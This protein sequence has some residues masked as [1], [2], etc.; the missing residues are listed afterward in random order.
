MRLIPVH[1]DYKGRKLVKNWTVYMWPEDRPYRDSN[2]RSQID[3]AE[4]S[5]GLCSRTTI[6]LIVYDAVLNNIFSR[7]RYSKMIRCRWQRAITRQELACC[8]WRQAI[9]N[10]MWY[11][12]NCCTSSI[13]LMAHHTI[14]AIINNHVGYC[15]TRKISCSWSHL[16]P[17]CTRCN[18]CVWY[19]WCGLLHKGVAIIRYKISLSL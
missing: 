4:S 15:W 8:Q 17:W 10:R 11:G 1:E 6:L 14:I 16:L 3:R 12:I 9:I 7:G 18:C 13:A 19:H 5:R 2:V